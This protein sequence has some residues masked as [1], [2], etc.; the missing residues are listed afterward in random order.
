MGDRW[1]VRG[2]ISSSRD[3][4]VPPSPTFLLSGGSS[5]ARLFL[6]QPLLLV[7]PEATIWAT[8]GQQQ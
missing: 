7:A 5:G 3:P 2:H 8:L 4:L 1:A 6:T